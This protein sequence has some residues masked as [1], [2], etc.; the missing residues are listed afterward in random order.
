MTTVIPDPFNPPYPRPVHQTVTAV[1]GNRYDAAAD[2]D[3]PV[4]AELCPCGNY[5]ERPC[6]DCGTPTCR[7][8]GTRTD[9][10][11][12]CAKD[13]ADRHR[14]AREV[15]AARRAEQ[16]EE[17]RRRQ[18]LEEA[19][20]AALPAA[21]LK[22]VREYLRWHGMG[23]HPDLWRAYRLPD[24]S[25]RRFGRVV[26]RAMKEQCLL[27][28]ARIRR[29]AW[30]RAVGWAMDGVGTEPGWLVSRWGRV[31]RISAERPCRVV[32][33]VPAA[34]PV[35]ASVLGSFMGG[36]RYWREYTPPDLR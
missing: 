27:G 2:G 21:T 8:D 22:Q 14:S 1:C 34:E 11:F 26:R 25:A 6:A 31:Y 35:P 12:V 33:R 18:V 4:D 9:G 15:E 23:P 30:F 16:A 7:D 24:L 36:S 19:R 17:E 29:R 32:R 13:A 5:A 10:G 3:A 28:A 20:R